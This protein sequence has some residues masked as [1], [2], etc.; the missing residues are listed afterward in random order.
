MGDEPTQNRK[1]KGIVSSISAVASNM[2]LTPTAIRDELRKAG[3]MTD[4]ERRAELE[5][6]IGSDK[7]RARVGLQQR[8]AFRSTGPQANT[9]GRD[10][11]HAIT[12]A[13]TCRA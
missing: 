8:D 7:G 6:I 4:Q 13:I 12:R 9:G 10:R 3:F 1:R 11:A 5:K 2:P